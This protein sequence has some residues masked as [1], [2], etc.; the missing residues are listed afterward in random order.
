M[1]CTLSVHP[2]C[3]NKNKSGCQ[4][5]RDQT[6][7]FTNSLHGDSSIPTL[8]YL[9]GEMFGH[10]LVV[11]ARGVSQGVVVVLSLQLDAEFYHLL[12]HGC[13]RPRHDVL[14]LIAQLNTGHKQITSL[15]YH[16]TLIHFSRQG[17]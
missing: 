2:V 7:V 8:L 5:G 17:L 6:I 14:N 1:F 9:M 11:E 4:K 15:Q 3:E 13:G 12:L 10:A 16:L